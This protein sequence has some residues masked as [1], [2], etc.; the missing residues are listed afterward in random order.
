MG[1]GYLGETYRICVE[2]QSYLVLEN[3]E[4]IGLVKYASKWKCG[5]GM[6]FNFKIIGV[7]LDNLSAL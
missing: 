1:H 2:M 4:D 6:G 5:L 3:C 7:L